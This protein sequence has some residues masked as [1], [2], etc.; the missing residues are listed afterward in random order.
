M[1]H[2]AICVI[3]ICCVSALYGCRGGNS[4]YTSAPSTVPNTTLASEPENAQTQTPTIDN[5]NGPV[6]TA[7]TNPNDTDSA[8]A[9][10]IST[11]E[12]NITAKSGNIGKNGTGT[13]VGTS[14]KSK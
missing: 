5:G 10:G 9:S 14:G 12:S 8:E 4:T 6:T 7:A 3:L 1:K 2:L 11:E 13:G